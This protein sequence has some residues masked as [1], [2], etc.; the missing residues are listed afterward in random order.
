VTE[1]IR[2][3]SQARVVEARD[4]DGSLSDSMIDIYDLT[5]KYGT[6]NSLNNSGLFQYVMY[7]ELQPFT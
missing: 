1:K 5:E 3:R 2:L 4:Q 7:L 6:L